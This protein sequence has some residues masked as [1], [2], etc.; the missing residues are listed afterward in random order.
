MPLAVWVAGSHR[1]KTYG[2]APYNGE[3]FPTMRL[4]GKV[5][6]RRNQLVKD[7]YRLAPGEPYIIFGNVPDNITV[8]I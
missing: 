6:A 1:A 7:L 2:K 5:C 8:S 4:F 3:T